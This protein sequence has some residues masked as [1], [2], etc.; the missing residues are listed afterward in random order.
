M[1]AIWDITLWKIAMGLI[2]FLIKALTQ[3]IVFLP[4]IAALGTML[5]HFFTRKN[6]FLKLTIRQSSDH[7]DIVGPGEPA[8]P[9]G[10]NH[11]PA[12]EP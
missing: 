3:N 4:A 10:G 9:I 1:H 12:A 11:T 7:V 6:L 8:A 5:V 2:D